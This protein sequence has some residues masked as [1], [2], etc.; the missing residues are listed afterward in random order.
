MVKKMGIWKFV[1]LPF[2]ATLVFLGTAVAVG[3]D[4]WPTQLRFMAGPSGGNW[5]A[6]GNAH[7]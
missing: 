6:L 3:N 1:F 2:A 5:S 7:R 4:D